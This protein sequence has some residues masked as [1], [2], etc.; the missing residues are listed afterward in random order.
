MARCRARVAVWCAV[1]TRC[2]HAVVDQP[3]CP[4]VMHRLLCHWEGFLTKGMSHCCMNQRDP[5]HWWNTT[6]AM[7]NM[8]HAWDQPVPVAG[9]LAATHAAQEYQAHAAEE[10]EIDMEMHPPALQP[11]HLLRLRSSL[12]SSQVG[13]LGSSSGVGGNRM[14]AAAAGPDAAAMASERRQLARPTLRT[15]PQ[16]RQHAVRTTN[17]G[18]HQAAGTG[19]AGTNEGSLQQQAAALQAQVTSASGHPDAPTAQTHPVAAAAVNRSHDGSPADHSGSGHHQAAAA[20]PAARA[21]WRADCPEALS[22]H[23]AVAAVEGH[24]AALHGSWHL[25]ASTTSGHGHRAAHQPRAAY[26]ADGGMRKRQRYATSG[27][28]TPTTRG[29]C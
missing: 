15:Q 2:C 28:C 17:G 18:R 12:Q 29:P 26:P 25:P 4:G 9:Q 13:H 21:V 14:Q 11:P 27:A 22:D 19:T 1:C 20:S 24:L 3:H 5:K 6:C 16:S 7:C 10:M 8:Q 23:H